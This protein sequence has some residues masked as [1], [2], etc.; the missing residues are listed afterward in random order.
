MYHNQNVT[1]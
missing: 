1:Y